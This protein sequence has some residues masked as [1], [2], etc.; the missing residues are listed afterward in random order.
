MI[1]LGAGSSSFSSPARPAFAFS[2]GRRMFPSRGGRLVASSGLLLARVVRRQRPRADRLDVEDRAVGQ[3]D[4]GRTGPTGAG[5][6]GG[7]AGLLP[8]GR[9]QARPGRGRRARQ[10]SERRPPGRVTRAWTRQDRATLEIDVG[11]RLSSWL[12]PPE[13]PKR[14]RGRRGRR[15]SSRAA[16]RP[17]AGR[18]SRSIRSSGA[19][20]AS[21]RRWS[22]PS[23]ARNQAE[24]PRDDG[25][26]GGAARRGG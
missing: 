9:G 4:A 3:R 10:A 18:M 7:R 26:A 23:R 11:D 14:A 6:A 15:A 20:S 2:P 1:S 8:V 19:P 24:S 5:P 25:G 16:R 17:P 12:D 13:R 22:E 21:A